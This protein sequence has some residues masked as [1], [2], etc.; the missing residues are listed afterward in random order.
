MPTEEK[1][2]KRQTTTLE[3]VQIIENHVAG[4]S[5]R[6]IAKELNVSKSGTQNIRFRY[7]VCHLQY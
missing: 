7:G 5:F 3:R 1:E 4:E 2:R 6:Q